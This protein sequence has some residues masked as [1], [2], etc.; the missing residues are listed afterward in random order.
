MICGL[1]RT[2]QIFTTVNPHRRVERYAPFNIANLMAVQQRERVLASMLAKDGLSELSG[3][4]VLDV[5]CGGGRLFLRLMSWGA[6]PES[7]H[8]IDVQAERVLRARSVHPK[9]EVVEGNAAVL[10]WDNERFDLVTQFTA[11]TSVADP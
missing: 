10:P 5:G 8:G 11:F 9:I 3:L 4:E 2:H 1:T 6:S 7:L